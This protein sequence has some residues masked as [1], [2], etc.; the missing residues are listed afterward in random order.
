MDKTND[1]DAEI[2]ALKTSSGCFAM[3]CSTIVMMVTST[4]MRGFVLSYAWL[5]FVVPFGV[6]PIGIAWAMGISFLAGLLCNS[7]TKPSAAA[8]KK[9]EDDPLVFVMNATFS[10]IALNLAGLGIAWIIHCFM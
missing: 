10:T 8:N 7:H 5:W 4:I 6:A 3:V 9:I 1:A 2:L